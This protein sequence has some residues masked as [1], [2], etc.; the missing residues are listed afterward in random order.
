MSRLL[1]DALPHRSRRYIYRFT[2]QSRYRKLLHKTARLSVNSYDTRFLRQTTK[3]YT[4]TTDY[5][6]EKKKCKTCTSGAHIDV[7][8]IISLHVYRCYIIF[9]SVMQWDV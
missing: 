1:V 5:T 7:V 3:L 8:C 4:G 9:F 6:F 2:L